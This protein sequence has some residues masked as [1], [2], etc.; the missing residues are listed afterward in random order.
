[1]LLF[2]IVN[3]VDANE[4]VNGH[5]CHGSNGRDNVTVAAA[6]SFCCVNNW[7]WPPPIAMQSPKKA[8][9]SVWTGSLNASNAEALDAGLRIRPQPK[10]ERTSVISDLHFLVAAF[11]H[12]VELCWGKALLV[13]PLDTVLSNAS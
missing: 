4:H 2:T 3:L 1:M 13:Q 11:L 12:S 7:P 10:R 5:V 6:F 9:H 8:A